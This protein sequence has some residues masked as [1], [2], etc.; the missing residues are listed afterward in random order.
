MA[1]Q[2]LLHA[3][4]ALYGHRAAGHESQQQANQWLNAFSQQPQ[5][6]DACLELLDP[7]RD[8]EVSFFCANMLLTKVRKEWHKVPPDQQL[9]MTAVIR[10]GAVVLALCRSQCCAACIPHTRTMGA[11]TPGVRWLRPHLQ[12][13]TPQRQ[14][15]DVPR[16]RR[17]LQGGHAAP[18][19]AAGRG[20]IPVWAGRDARLFGAVHGHG[21]RRHSGRR[22]AAGAGT[23][24]PSGPGL[25]THASRQWGAAA[26]APRSLGRAPGKA[27]ISL[28]DAAAAPA[29]TP[30]K[31]RRSTRPSAGCRCCLRSRMRSQTWTGRSARTWWR[32]PALCGTKW[33]RPHKRWRCRALGRQ[34]SGLG[35]LHLGGAALG[36]THLGKQQLCWCIERRAPPSQPCTGRRAPRGAAGRAAVP[37]LVAAPE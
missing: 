5:A 3:I 6:W 35:A 31:H 26:A 37:G 18:G 24:P 36:H 34:V 28:C 4:S 10:C 22:A 21:G 19:P 17:R 7:A 1:S 9:R 8:P 13:Q 23:R 14:V 29:Q 25:G 11:P 15:H 12:S 20:R 2:E 27:A 16:R 30:P 33:W 32:R